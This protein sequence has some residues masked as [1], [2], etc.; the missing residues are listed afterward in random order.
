MQCA[1]VNF[2]ITFRRVFGRRFLSTVVTSA[3]LRTWTAATNATAFPTARSPCTRPSR[4][5]EKERARERNGHYLSDIR[6]IFG[7]LDPLHVS[8]TEFTQ[9]RLFCLP[10]GTSLPIHCGRHISMPHKGGREGGRERERVMTGARGKGHRNTSSLLYLVWL[11][12]VLLA[13]KWK[14]MSAIQSRVAD[15]RHTPFLR[16]MEGGHEWVSWKTSSCRLGVSELGRMEKACNFPTLQW[17]ECVYRVRWGEGTLDLT[18][19]NRG[20]QG[21]RLQVGI[22]SL[23]ETG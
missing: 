4:E 11:S 2:Q 14:A 9:P 22:R 6:K 7:F 19:A 5:R 10:F 12:V 13:L 15:T 17:S 18:E 1:K 23:V 8:C 16:Q 20:D 21:H 3:F